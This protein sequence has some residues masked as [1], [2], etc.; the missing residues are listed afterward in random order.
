[1]TT[2][3]H[4]LHNPRDAFAVRVLLAVSADTSIGSSSR[5]TTN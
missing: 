4:P 5:S 1:M 3:I 2:G